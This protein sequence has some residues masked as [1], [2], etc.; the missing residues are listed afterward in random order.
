[1]SKHNQKIID[2][3]KQKKKKWRWFTLVELIVVITIIAILGTIAFISLQNYTKNSRDSQ[4]IADINSI[5]KSLWAYMAEKWSYPDPD[6][7]TNI[8]YSGWLAWTQWTVWDTMITNL[9]NINKKPTDPLTFN[10]YTYS[11]TS[12]KN[13][14]QI[15]AIQEV[16]IVGNIS[17]VE[18]ANAATIWSKKAMAMVKWNYNQVMLKVS[19]WSVDYILAVPSIINADLSDLDLLSII[20]KRQLVYNNRENLPDSYKWAWYSMTWWFDYVPTGNKVEI[21]KWSL[22]LLNWDKGL[23]KEMIETLKQA[24]NWSI[25]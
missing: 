4:R 5:E 20:N 2:K 22:W 24:Y 9:K 16:W 18:K 19:T 23:K 14:Y 25:I 1:M 7:G 12:Y 13:E 10:E 17:V 6:L 3:T 21:Y 11:V 15:W 8:T